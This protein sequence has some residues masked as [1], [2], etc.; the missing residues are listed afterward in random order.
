MLV[1]ITATLIL[2]TLPL[3]VSTAHGQIDQGLRQL[4]EAR[5]TN[6]RVFAADTRPLGPVAIEAVEEVQQQVPPSH[7]AVRVRNRSA[8]PIV[9]VTVAAVVVSSDGSTKA[10]Q[11]LTP[12]KNLKPDQA[13][14]QQT[15]IRVAVL[16]VT[17]RV[18]FVPYEVT[19]T[20]GT[21]TVPDQE[22]RA[23]V[24]QAAQRLPVK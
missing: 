2:V 23:A 3:P 1:R 21:W 18:A 22:L 17:D 24:K 4:S 5:G 12:F 20:E 8:E 7:Y 11:R 6:W 14:R 13:R 9:S 16:G 19:T 10:V 15:A